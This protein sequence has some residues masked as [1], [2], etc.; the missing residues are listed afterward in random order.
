IV[1]EFYCTVET[2]KGNTV[3][4]HVSYSYD[5]TVNGGSYRTGWT[6]LEKRDVTGVTYYHYRNGIYEK[7]ADDMETRDKETDKNKKNKIKWLE[8]L[9]KGVLF[10]LEKVFS[11]FLFRGRN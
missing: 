11:A 1:N 8:N 7:M 4:R 9:I 10:V 2:A 5:I 6:L 3:T